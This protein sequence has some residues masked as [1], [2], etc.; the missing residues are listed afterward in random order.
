[1]TISV[2]PLTDSLPVKLCVRL[3]WESVAE[4]FRKNS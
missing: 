2:S 1:M 3:G 4:M